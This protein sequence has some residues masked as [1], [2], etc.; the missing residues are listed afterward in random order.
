MPRTKK[1]TNEAVNTVATEEKVERKDRIKRIKL[2]DDYTLCMDTWNYWIMK[3][4]VVADVNKI[5]GKR[6]KN[7]G[8][9]VDRAIDGYH[10]SLTNCFESFFKAVPNLSEAKS[11]TAILK[12][13]REA[14]KRIKQWCVNI[15]AELKAY[16]K[17][18]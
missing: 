12:C 11:I 9:D 17:G 4:D 10:T 5:T 8:K 3:K 16:A 14:E 6:S 1:T 18:K 13:E 15:E 7:A 2:D